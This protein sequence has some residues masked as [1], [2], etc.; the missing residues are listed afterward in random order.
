[1]GVSAQIPALGA[2]PIRPAPAGSHT[3][4]F[5]QVP[6]LCDELVM[7]AG[8]VVVV[9]NYVT[10]T[11]GTMPPNP[12]ITARIGYG[13]TTIITNPLWDFEEQVQALASE[14]IPAVNSLL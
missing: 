11:S 14:V 6:A 9:T 7:P 12:A 8:G 2:V 5:V 13:A 10:V 1:M 4:T 3:T